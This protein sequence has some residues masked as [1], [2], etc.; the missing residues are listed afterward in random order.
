MNK[1][2]GYDDINI[3][4]VEKATPGGHRCIV[5]K[6]IEGKSKAGKEQLEIWLDMAPDD[7]QP[8]LFTNQYMNNTADNKKWPCRFWIT[9]YETDDNGKRSL[10]KFHTALEDSNANF[11]IQW[12]TVYAE[13]I[14]GRRVGVVF[15]EEE[16]EW[17]GRTITLV[18]PY[19]FRNIL[20]VEK[21]PVPDKKLLPKKETWAPASGVAGDEGFLQVPEDALDDEGLPFR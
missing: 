16:N 6:V 13:S 15:R 14:K 3:N 2:S 19:Y 11:F 1:P 20:E 7:S 8:M 17:Q 4:M 9:G 10:K 5:T 18:K 12:G 21:E